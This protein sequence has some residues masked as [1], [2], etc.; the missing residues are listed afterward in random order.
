[1]SVLP[2]WHLSIMLHT[3]QC[4]PLPSSPHPTPSPLSQSSDEKE[5]PQ[6]QLKLLEEERR[7]LEKE[8]NRYLEQ[9]KGLHFQL[10]K[11]SEDN[12]SQVEIAAQQTKLYESDF[13]KERAQR[14]KLLAK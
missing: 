7:G 6:V 1:M 8:K 9:I 14:E 4:Q 13:E 11:A 10:E 3:L 2:L 5:K 12:M